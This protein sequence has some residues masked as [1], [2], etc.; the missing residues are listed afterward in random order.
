M[1]IAD[2]EDFFAGQTPDFGDADF[3]RSISEPDF[4]QDS[5]VLTQSG[6]D[7]HV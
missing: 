7:Q 5:G 3:V 4:L 2:S 6:I 1:A